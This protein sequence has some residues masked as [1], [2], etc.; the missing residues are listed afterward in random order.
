[1]N[2][3]IGLSVNKTDLDVE[4]KLPKTIDEIAA[5][6]REEQAELER[7]SASMAEAVVGDEDIESFIEAYISDLEKNTVT[8]ENGQRHFARRNP[9]F[10]R[11]RLRKE[12]QSAID[13]LEK[14]KTIFQMEQA[15]QIK[16]IHILNR[17]EIMAQN[18][19]AGLEAVIQ[20][21]TTAF[22]TLDN[23]S[24]NNKEEFCRRYQQR[25]DSLKTSG[26]VALQT[27]GQ[28]RL[29]RQTS[30]SLV[31]KLQDAVMHLIP[32]WRNQLSLLYGIQQ[33]KND[34]D[35]VQK[36]FRRT[37]RGGGNSS[38]LRLSELDRSIIGFLKDVQKAYGKISS[39]TTAT[40]EKTDKTTD[41]KGEQDEQ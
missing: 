12:Y 16:Q 5:F 41:K 34:S 13:G 17:I 23:D 33:G 37:L 40:P 11:N 19:S 1:M 6:G 38:T 15:K 24:I 32:L 2:D 29:L 28:I 35:E 8:L 7:I 31:D 27:L 4:I 18:C 20:T 10:G 14:L 3:T 9:F 30:V 39:N 21:G 25:L 22:Q 36:A 26:V